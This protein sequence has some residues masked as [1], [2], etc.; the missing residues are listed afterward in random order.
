MD[1]FKGRPAASNYNRE[2]AVEYAH[3][4]AMKRNPGYLDFEKYGGDCTN[5]AS[6]VIYAGSGMMNYTPVH[7][8][9]YFN[10]RNRSPAWTDVDILYNFL[11]KNKGRGPYA[12]EVDVKDVRPGDI[13]QL[14]FSGGGDYNHSPII[15][16]TG[17]IPKEDNILIASHTVDRDYY[18]LTSYNWVDIRFIHIIE[19]R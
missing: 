7:G 4:W 1:G 18:P 10:S 8:W 9:Y 11:I 3:K 13:T 16:Q 19:A 17:I 15:V 2:K 12:E 5:F 6:Q 14:S